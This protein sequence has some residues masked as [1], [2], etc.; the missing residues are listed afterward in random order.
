MA[1]QLHSTDRDE[2]AADAPA[3]GSH[4]LFWLL[5]LAALLI[6]VWSVYNRWAS[7]TTPAHVQPV[8]PAASPAHRPASRA[9]DAQPARPGRN[10]RS[11]ER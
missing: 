1:R 11:P 2:P 8:V 4:P 6:I 10:P 7:E 9:V 5:V 3:R